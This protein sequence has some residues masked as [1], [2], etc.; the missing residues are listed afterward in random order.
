[1]RTTRTQPTESRTSYAPELAVARAPPEIEGDWLGA[2]F[3]A[4]DGAR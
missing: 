3:G 1:M 4:G 2:C